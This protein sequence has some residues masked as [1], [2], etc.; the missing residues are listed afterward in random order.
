MDRQRTDRTRMRLI[1]FLALTLHLFFSAAAY[2]AIP[3]NYT[4]IYDVETYSTVVGRS[5]IRLDQDNEKLLYSQEI[6]LV[7]IAAWF[8]D[9]HVSEKSWLSKTDNDL[10]LNRY[11]YIHS[12][13]DRKKNR[14]VLLEGRWSDDRK[15]SEFNG[16]AL[17]NKTSIKSEGPLWDILSVQLALINDIADSVGRDNLSY[18]VLSKGALNHYTFNLKGTDL[19]EV[20]EK[21]YRTLK[22]E[23]ISGNKTIRL[24]LAPKLH[25]IPVLIE[26][27]KNGELDTRV[28]LD[29][30]TFNKQIAESSDDN[31]DLFEE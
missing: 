1:T 11:E 17:G 24:Y 21:V 14:D 3:P 29:S 20:N 23:R 8:K 5:T 25:N 6:E 26:K 4:A 22:A 31:D 16:T 13:G 12:N 9:D 27:Y 15:S 28:L 19:V 7:G 18:Q 10:L 2:S 30:V